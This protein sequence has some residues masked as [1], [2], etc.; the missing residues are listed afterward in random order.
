MNRGEILEVLRHHLT[1]AQ[2]EV[3]EVQVSK[4]IRLGCTGRRDAKSKH[5]IIAHLPVLPSTLSSC[6]IFNTASVY[7]K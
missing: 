1:C 5:W 3:V 7:D 2:E 6:R 4:L